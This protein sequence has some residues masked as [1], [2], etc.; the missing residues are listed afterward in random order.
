MTGSTLRFRIS[1]AAVCLL[2]A[3]TAAHAQFTS[4][5]IYGTVLDPGGAAIPGATVQAIHVDTGAV[6]RFVSD[7]LG[8]YDFPEIRLGAYRLEAEAAGFQ[9][10][11][12]TGLSLDLN[13]RARVDLV[14]QVGS[15]TETVEV[16]AQT[17]LVDTATAATGQV[18]TR[19]QVEDLPILSRIPWFLGLIS[20]G[21]N[22]Q[23][24]MSPGAAL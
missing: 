20:A 19:K 1:L 13:Q 3:A 10:L 24:D 9:K 21:V 6:Y 8:N 16:T 18:V 5:A 2:L 17:P 14:L 15:V 11:A 23:R 7:S 4:A 12:R 22:P